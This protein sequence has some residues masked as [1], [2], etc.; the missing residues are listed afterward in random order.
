MGKVA[1]TVVV[2][3]SVAVPLPLSLNITPLGRLPVSLRLGVGVPEVVTVKVP[4]MPAV[5]VV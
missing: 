5:K 4:A 2:P 3:A 1:A